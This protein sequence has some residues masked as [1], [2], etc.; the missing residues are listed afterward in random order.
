M[1]LPKKN[2]VL[3]IKPTNLANQVDQAAESYYS[4]SLAE[5][6]AQKIKAESNAQIKSL[7]ELFGVKSGKEHLVVTSRN[8]CGYLVV[9][10]YSLNLK[11]AKKI[12]DPEVLKKVKVRPPPIIDQEKFAALVDSGEITQQQARKIIVEGEPIKRIVVRPRKG[13]PTP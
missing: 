1:K 8:E 9:S 12:L 10:Q 5:K 4:A 3:A 11:I 7:A 2:A 13:I 6:E